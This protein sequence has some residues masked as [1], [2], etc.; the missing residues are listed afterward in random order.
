MD[1]DKLL[2]EYER[3]FGTEPRIPIMASYS[4]IE[5]EIKEAIIRKQP[6]TPEEIEEAYRG[7]PCDQGD[8]DI[9][10]MMR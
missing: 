1:I 2:E 9:S 7:I 4:V 8:A 6:L 5:Q 10:K 3:L